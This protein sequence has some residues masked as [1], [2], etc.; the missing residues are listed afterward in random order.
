M[1]NV[2]M[3]FEAWL[4][5]ATI[6]T[7]IVW[8]LDKLVFA[9][10]R[11]DGDAPNWAIEFSRSFFPVLLAVLV[12]RAFVFEPFRIPSKSMV[13][14]LLVGDFVL[15]N[16]FAYGLRAPVF[17]TK[18]VDLGEPE[19][20]DVVVFRYPP[21]PT[22]DYIKRIIGLPGDQ[23][24][25]SD[26]HL[27][28]NGKRVELA[29]QGVYDDPDADV[30]DSMR[31]LIEDLPDAQPHPVL[32]VVGRRGPEVSVTVPDG[33]YFVMGDNRDNSA[34]SRIWG[35][36]PEKNFVGKAFMIWMSIDFDDFGV[37]WARIGHM[38]H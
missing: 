37:R 21:D 17:H 25:Y 30:R 24:T 3:D 38:L 35:F 11:Y 2:H 7:G 36:V 26:E 16:K 6:I 33:H 14:T 1:S 19:R 31:K 8:L 15:V 10:R 28:I 20:G 13:P 32:Q 9:P 22:K 12:L 27:S 23:I 34:D 5:L 4:A 18:F 29:D